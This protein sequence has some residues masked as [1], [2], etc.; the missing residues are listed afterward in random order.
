MSSDIVVIGGLGPGP[1]ELLSSV[2][3]FNLFK[4]AWTPLAELK[5]GRC[6][7]AAVLFENQILVCDGSC[8][9]PNEYTD[10]IEVLDL[11]GSPPEWKDF[12][13]N[14]PVKVAAHKCVVY[15]WESFADYW[16]F[17]GSK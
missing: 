2:E 4:Q 12:A 13:V 15:A 9:G 16:R 8:G 5:I 17:G 1:D 10:S 7:H 11:T 14:L 3:Q 6:A